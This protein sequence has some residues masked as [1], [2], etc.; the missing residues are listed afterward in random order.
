LFK[1]VAAYHQYYAV[2]KAVEQTLRATNAKEGD[3]KVGVVWHTQGSGKS[4]SMVFYAGQMLGKAS[5]K[6]LAFPYRISESS[7]VVTTR[8]LKPY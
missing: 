3:R 2:Q 5:R 7:L 6:Y 8:P 1:K 4:L